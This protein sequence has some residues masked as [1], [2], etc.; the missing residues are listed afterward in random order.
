MVTATEQSPAYLKEL[1]RHFAD[2]RD[3]THGDGAG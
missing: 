1:M 3:G 2:L